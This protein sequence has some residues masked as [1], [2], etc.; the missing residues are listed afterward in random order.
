[1]IH[2][3]S[4]FTPPAPHRT[5]LKPK[6]DPESMEHWTPDL[7]TQRGERVPRHL[8]AY[9]V[10][11]AFPVEHLRPIAEAV[12][13]PEMLDKHGDNHLGA[14]LFHLIDTGKKMTLLH[15][16][17]SATRRPF[18]LWVHRVFPGLPHGQEPPRHLSEK[19]W[20]LFHDYLKQRGVS[21]EVRESMRMCCIE[22]P[23]GCCLSGLGAGKSSQQHTGAGTSEAAASRAGEGWDGDNETSSS[24]GGLNGLPV[25]ALS[26]MHCQL[27]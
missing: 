22:W 12:C 18:T 25:A 15:V 11:A 9:A 8:V 1:M 26:C 2:I 10:G 6:L 3:A 13:S 21:D 20:A 5:A 4:G 14:L 24:R 16:Q 23:K 19:S 27:A 17:D 7:C